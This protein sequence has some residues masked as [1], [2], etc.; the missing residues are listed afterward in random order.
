ML[1]PVPVHI[2]VETGSAWSWILPLITNAVLVAITGYYAWEARQVRLV[3]TKDS[4]A[5]EAERRKEGQAENYRAE[6]ARMTLAALQIALQSEMPVLGRMRATDEWM[7]TSLDRFMVNAPA[8]IE[9]SPQALEV[10]LSLLRTMQ[11]AGKPCVDAG[12]LDVG[13]GKQWV[14]AEGKLKQHLE[15]TVGPTVRGK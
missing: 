3:A 12:T 7:N 9:L 14:L 13:H 4:D 8:L 10:L 1:A 11:I 6:T 15:S 2:T 5:R